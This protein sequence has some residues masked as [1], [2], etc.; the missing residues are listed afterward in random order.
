MKVSEQAKRAALHRW[1]AAMH[2]PE[3]IAAAIQAAYDID[4]N[5]RLKEARK[6][7]EQLVSMI[8]DVSG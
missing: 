2:E 3:S 1:S 6:I 4:C 5:P 8:D 7:I